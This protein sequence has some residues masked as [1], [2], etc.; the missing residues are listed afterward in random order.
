VARPLCAARLGRGGRCPA[1]TVNIFGNL[2]PNNSDNVTIP[3]RT[4]GVKFW[5]TQSGSIS[6]IRFYRGTTSPL[7]HVASLYSARGTLLGSVT[8]AHES[9]AMP[10][11]QVATF[12]SPISISPNTT[13]VAAYYIPS[14]KYQRMPYGLTQGVTTGPLT[15]PAS[16]TVGGN[17]IY[18]N[19][20]TFPTMKWEDANFFV[21]VEFTPTAPTPYL[22]LSFNPA[23]PSIASNAPGGTVVATITAN[24]SNGSPFT[25]ALT[26]GPPNSNDKATFSISGNNLIVNP[27]GPG[28]SADGST[29]QRV[30]IVA[31]Q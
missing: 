30:T 6:A 31:T 7:G 22:T 18:R 16:S 19:G 15:A 9:G 14:G 8:M 24:W 17:G 29:T 23:N 20:Q 21:D 27:A 2:V 28:V 11:W 26:F 13:Y 4:V 1:Q 12:A 5:S 3:P 25:G 10:G